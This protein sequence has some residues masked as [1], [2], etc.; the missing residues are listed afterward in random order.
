MSLFLGEKV[1]RRRG[2]LQ[3]KDNYPSGRQ[4]SEATRLLTRKW[5][6]VV[7]GY[8]PVFLCNLDNTYPYLHIDKSHWE[9]LA[10]LIF[11]CLNFSLCG[12]YTMS[13]RL[14]VLRYK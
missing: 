9:N 4:A 5:K 7:S 10:H 6:L 8:S 1:I 3:V 11:S 14:A 2:V 13:V 12:G